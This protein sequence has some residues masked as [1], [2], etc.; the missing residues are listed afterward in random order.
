[1]GRTAAPAPATLAAAAVLEAQAIDARGQKLL[2]QG[3]LA[4]ARSLFERAVEL[5]P[6]V[7]WSHNNIALC[8]YLEGDLDAAVAR[9]RLVIAEIA[10]E[11]A[12]AHAALAQYL[13]HLGRRSEAEAVARTN[14]ALPLYDGSAIGK[15]CETLAHL[16]W[17]AELAALVDRP[18]LRPLLEAGSRIHGAVAHANL[19]RREEALEWL[20]GVSERPGFVRALRRGLRRGEGPGTVDGRWAYFS[21][22]SEFV[23]AALLDRVR[24]EI[25]GADGSPVPEAWFAGLMLRLVVLEMNACSGDDPR[26]A[27]LLADLGTP[28]AIALLRRIAAGRFGSD[29]LRSSAVLGL[30]RIAA[31]RPGERP[32]VWSEREGR[33]IEVT[34]FE[35]TDEAVTPRRMSDADTSLLE[36]ALAALRAGR[37]QDALDQLEAL[38]ARVP[39]EVSIIHNRAVALAA[40]GR[41]EAAREIYEALIAADPTYLFPRAALAGLDIADG[42]LDAARATVEGVEFPDRV[43]PD[44][45][46]AYL[47]VQIL[48]ELACG[49]AAKARM[50]VD[51]TEA[52]GIDSPALDDARRRVEVVTAL[53]RAV[54]TRASHLAEAG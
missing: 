11:S 21:T 48:L 26:H 49:D 28:E 47:A 1:M 9:E 7:P 33:A 19:G 4:E 30:H 36:T 43:D 37:A 3:R 40:L 14:L 2:G 44:A 31:L 50:L 52:L 20:R 46:A 27:R 53:R 6:T 10:P 29:D 34:A 51:R 13:L 18:E 45:Y 17:D 23:S 24:A 42:R 54:E 38:Q 22:A 25:A 5:A 32:S 15:V 39:D 12:F 41:T 35:I 16:E 8:D